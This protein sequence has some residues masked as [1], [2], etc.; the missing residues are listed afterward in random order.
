MSTIIMRIALFI[1]SIVLIIG[2]L[3]ILPLP[4]PFGAIMIIIGVSI[5]ISSNDT[6]AGWIRQRRI[7]NPGLNQRLLAIEKRL[8]SRLSAII[9]RTTP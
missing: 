6:A 1:L 9:R 8:P 3:I 2:G 7:N 5:L 4:I